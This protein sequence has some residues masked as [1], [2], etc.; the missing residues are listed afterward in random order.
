MDPIRFSRVYSRIMTTIKSFRKKRI[1]MSTRRNN[2]NIFTHLLA[3]LLCGSIYR[4]I[5][6]LFER[7]DLN[8]DWSKIICGFIITTMWA[9]QNL[10]A[11]MMC[12]KW[13]IFSSFSI[14]YDTFKAE[15]ER[16]KGLRLA[17]IY[18][19]WLFLALLLNN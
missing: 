5:A 7:F 11:L 1:V 3:A 12:Y 2:V 8:L 6:A 18:V 14:I 16:Y 10:A 9:V 13:Y 17:Y 4:K 15:W 19:Y